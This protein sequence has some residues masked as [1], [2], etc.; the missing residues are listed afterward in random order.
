MDVGPPA[1]VTKAV[2][3]LNW[4][5]VV[6]F[7]SRADGVY[8]PATL[9]EGLGQFSFLKEFVRSLLERTSNLS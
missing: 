4:V 9:Q 6:G 1:G 5:S 8:E 7:K 2:S 3:N